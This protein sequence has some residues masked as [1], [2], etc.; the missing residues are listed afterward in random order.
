MGNRVMNDYKEPDLSQEQMIQDISEYELGFI[1]FAETLN[2]ARTVL[3]Q[4]YRDMSYN[5]LVKAYN[6][7]FG[8]YPD[9]M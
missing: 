7:V 8:G 3:R 9:E 4:K 5:Q 1:G 2:I 6:Q